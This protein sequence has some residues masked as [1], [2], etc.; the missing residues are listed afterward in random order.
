MRHDPG[1]H[2][3]R[4]RRRAKLGAL[5]VQRSKAVVIRLWKRLQH[6]QV[7]KSTF[8]SQTYPKEW[9]LAWNQTRSSR[10]AERSHCQASGPCSNVSAVLHRANHTAYQPCSFGNTFTLV[11]QSGPVGMQALRTNQKRV[12]AQPTSATFLQ[13]PLRR[14]A[15][16]VR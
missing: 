6:L 11:G 9:K 2:I 4:N 15:V 10:L 7:V 5:E 16:P 12:Q 14:P 3:D 8:T 1:N 13:E